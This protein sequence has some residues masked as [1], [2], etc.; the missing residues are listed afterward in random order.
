MFGGRDFAYVTVVAPGAAGRRLARPGATTPRRI[1]D[2]LLP[3]A[4]ALVAL[5]FALS[6][7]AVVRSRP[8]GQK[9]LWAAGFLLFAVATACEAVA[10]RHRLEP[11]SSAP[12]TC[13]GGVLTVGFLGAGSAWLS[14]RRGR[15]V[16]LGALAVGSRRGAVTVCS[17]PSTHS[18][19]CRDGER[20][21]ARERRLGGHAFLWAVAFN[22]LG[23]LA[24]VGGSL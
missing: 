12:T 7:R 24:L 16:L 20:A 8:A 14:P 22:S 21:A 18:A 10:Q 9:A 4:A 23:T 15:D 11:C 13:A 1:A 2:A 3:V 5:L 19:A 17:R 6:A